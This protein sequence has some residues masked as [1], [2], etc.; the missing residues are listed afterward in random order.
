M[1]VSQREAKRCI[2]DAYEAASNSGERQYVGYTADGRMWRV[3]AS[4][5]PVDQSHWLVLPNGDTFAHI[6]EKGLTEYRYEE[7]P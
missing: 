3:R 5:P 4:Q 6:A 7:L 1:L 2:Q